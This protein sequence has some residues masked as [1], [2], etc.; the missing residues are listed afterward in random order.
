[1]LRSIIREMIPVTSKRLFLPFGV[2]WQCPRVSPSFTSPPRAAHCSFVTKINNGVRMVAPMAVFRFIADVANRRAG[3]LA[4]LR[5]RALTSTSIAENRSR[6]R[7]LHP[8][9]IARAFLRVR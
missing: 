1:M 4:G 7:K 2:R 9:E 6:T 3:R 8:E 5:C